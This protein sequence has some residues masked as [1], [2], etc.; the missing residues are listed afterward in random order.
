MCCVPTFPFYCSVSVFQTINC[1]SIPF[2]CVVHVS[3]P[4]H[5]VCMISFPDHSTGVSEGG[6]NLATGHQSNPI[7]SNSFHT[8][9]RFNHRFL[10]QVGVAWGCG[11]WVWQPHTVGKAG[12]YYCLMYTVLR[13]LP[14]IA[15]VGE[16]LIGVALTPSNP[17]ILGSVGS[18]I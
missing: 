15:V 18:V 16:A 2:Y 7:L 3:V 4:F 1:V 5:F 10:L 14:A 11:Q 12:P 8:L 6:W 17:V 9:P 13:V